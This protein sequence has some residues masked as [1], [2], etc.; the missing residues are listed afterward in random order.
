VPRVVEPV[1]VVMISTGGP[2]EDDEDAW[3]ID[4]GGVFASSEITDGEPESI[5]ASLSLSS[6]E[7]SSMLRAPLLDWRRRS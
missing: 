1:A 5:C 4:N 2:S 7:S 3:D 6:S